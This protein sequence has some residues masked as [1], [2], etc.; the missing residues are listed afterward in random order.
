MNVKIENW[1]LLVLSIFYFI[2]AVLS[3]AIE[4]EQFLSFFRILGIMI[5]LI[6]LLQILIY[7]FKKNYLKPQELSFSFGIL[8]CLT[9]LI[10]ATKPH[11]IVDNY[12][13]V[14]SAV[15]AL[16]STLRLQY[17]MNLFRLKDAQW[18]LNLSFAVVPLFLAV[19]IL[20]VPMEDVMLHNVF[21]FLLIIDA[22]ANFYTIFY[23][24]RILKRYGGCSEELMEMASNDELVKEH[25][26]GEDILVKKTDPT[27]DLM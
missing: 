11:V 16:D 8:C 17:S 7:F 18:K 12:P 20:L 5:A 25:Y 10:V 27:D 1:K 14:I 13:L 23:Y 19:C 3:Y 15:A 22:V 6:G 26:D 21:S 4:K 24:K 2:F 9:G